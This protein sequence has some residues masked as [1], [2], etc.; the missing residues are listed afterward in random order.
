MRGLE[1]ALARIARRDE[2]RERSTVTRRSDSVSP[3]VDEV[4]DA[5]RAVVERNPGV[6]ATVVV[7]EAETAWSVWI[8]EWD[9]TLHTRVTT[10]DPDPPVTDSAPPLKPGASPSS[11]PAVTPVTAPSASPAV[12][13]AASPSASPAVTPV[14]APVTPVAAPVPAALEPAIPLPRRRPMSPANRP[15]AALPAGPS[16]QPGPAPIADLLR[17]RSADSLSDAETPPM[18]FRPPLVD[19]GAPLPKRFPDSGIPLPRRRPAPPFG[20]PLGQG[21]P[22]L[23]SAPTPAATTLPPLSAPRAALA[24]TIP[25]QRSPA[26]VPGAQAPASRL[27]A[28]LEDTTWPPHYHPSHRVERASH[29]ADPQPAP[30]GAASALPVPT[31]PAPPLAAAQRVS[32]PAMNDRVAGRIAEMLRREAKRDKHDNRGLA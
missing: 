28:E 17:P 6:F 20:A 10:L 21:P 27:S 4:A 3:V 24:G 23:P 18:G 15:A 29:R 19:A 9:G 5:L 12:T 31:M 11:S 8:G 7:Q 1:D 14:A 2:L 25:A 22:A 32:G 26:Q 16:P 13:P 30:A